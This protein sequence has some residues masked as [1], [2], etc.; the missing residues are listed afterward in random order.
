VRER[1]AELGLRGKAMPPGSVDHDS[2]AE[3]YAEVLKMVV[4]LAEELGDY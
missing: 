1:L 2:L 3:Q 4:G